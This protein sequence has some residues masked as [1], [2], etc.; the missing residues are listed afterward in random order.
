[1]ISLD[2]IR[3]ILRTILDPEMPINIVD[4]GIVADV[5]CDDAGVEIDITPTFVGCPALDVLR[6]E[7]VGRLRAAGAMNVQV[8]FIHDPPWSV[9]KISDDG[10]AALRVHG[11]TVPQHGTR[12]GSAAATLV[13][14]SISPAESVA[15]PYCGSLRTNM[16]SAFG[17]T[18]CRTIYY[19][20][21][22]RNQ[23]EHMKA[24]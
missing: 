8:R 21:G 16:E 23:F 2:D 5:R 10:R 4:L 12:I 6:A 22:C 14:L 3:S 17:P 20:A 15:C 19:C 24:I 7:I 1:M 9:K 13:P 11:V 18:R